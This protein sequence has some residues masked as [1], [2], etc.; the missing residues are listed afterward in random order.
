MEVDQ[1]LKSRP[2]DPSQRDLLVSARVRRRQSRAEDARSPCGLCSKPVSLTGC[3]GPETLP[4][5]PTMQRRSFIQ[6]SLATV[7]ASAA[8]APAI[9]AEPQGR[10]VYELR[11]YSL[12]A[13]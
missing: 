2:D 12:N 9:G 11:T 1:H 5:T 6:A 7:C 4:R 8:T 3:P 13:A 10:P